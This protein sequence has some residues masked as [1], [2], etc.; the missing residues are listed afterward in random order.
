MMSETAEKPFLRW[1][2]RRDIP[3]VLA[4]LNSSDKEWDESYLIR[5]LRDKKSLG[6]V[7]DDGVEVLGLVLYKMYSSRFEVTELVVDPDF[8]RQGVGSM[9]IQKLMSNLGLNK[10]RERRLIEFEV[11]GRNLPGLQFL[12]AHGFMAVGMTSDNESY[13]MQFV[14]GGSKSIFQNRIT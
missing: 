5:Y 13:L 8:Q 6:M 3:D 12:R 14:K 7:V 9:L 1:M 4:I 11:Q 2:I 10:T